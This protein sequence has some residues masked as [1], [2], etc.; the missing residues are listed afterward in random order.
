GR[1]AGGQLLGEKFV[2]LF[3]LRVGRVRSGRLAA[4]C[5]G[6]GTQEKK[7]CEMA[8]GEGSAHRGSQSTISKRYSSITGLVST[9]LEIRSSC[10]CAS[11]RLQP[12]RLRTKNF[13]WRT[14][15]TW[16]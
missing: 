14:S 4:G 15:L 8:T 10:F 12:S 5:D 16:P 3:E 1:G 9:S 13:P 11:S 6:R 7:R 2:D